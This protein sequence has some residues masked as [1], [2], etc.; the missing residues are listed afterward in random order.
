MSGK[1]AFN[2]GGG[3]EALD[4]MRQSVVDGVSN[5]ASTQSLEED[6][7]RVFS[8]GQA[9]MALNWTYMYG[10][11]NDPK[12]SQVS[13]KVGVAQ[14]PSA[15][16]GRPG[17]N[18][19]MALAVT[20][21]SKN[22][23]A[24]W[25]YITYLTSQPVQDKYAVSSLPVW[26]A[27][28]TDPAVIKTNP[29]VV[30]QAKKQLGDLILRPQVK[31]YNGISQVL[32]A[33][34]QNALLNKKSSQQALDD[35]ASKGEPPCST[36]EAASPGPARSQGEGLFALALLL[37]AALVVFGVVLYPVIRTFVVSLFA[38]DSPLAGTYPFVGLEQLHP[39][40]PRQRLLRS[41]GPH[42]LLHARVPPASS[43][44]GRRGRAPAEHAVARHAGCGAA[45]W[46]FPGPFRPS[47]TGRC[48]A[49]ST[50]AS[51]APSTGC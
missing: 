37:P 41:P 18:G 12:E 42:P 16:G 17:V 49:G 31:N 28:Y 44:A 33:E 4:F 8:A 13:G 22:Q 6:V 29:E 19:S 26:E 27:S 43:W 38:V 5:P 1:P 40:V 23:S 3:V 48:G 47:S 25:K 7:R 34:I 14:T 9:S 21:G 11:A 36:R 51:T 2:R 50:T 35:A 45:S 10:L 39:G 15:S 20:G 30:P 32:Q 46:S 24:A